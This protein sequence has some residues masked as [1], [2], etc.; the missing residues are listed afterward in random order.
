LKKCVK[1]TCG[2]QIFWV[3]LEIKEQNTRTGKR[4]KLLPRMRIVTCAI[5][6]WKIHEIEIFFDSEFV[7][8]DRRGVA[9]EA[10]IGRL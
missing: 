3:Y 4:S 6:S 10:Y 9:V 2:M 8:P 7:G 5:A 1:I